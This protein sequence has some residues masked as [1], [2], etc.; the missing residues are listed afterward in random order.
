MPSY[1]LSFP[2]LGNPNGRVMEFITDDNEPPR[3]AAVTEIL[4]R[5]GD[6][7]PRNGTVE[8]YETLTLVFLCDFSLVKPG[9]WRL[10]FRAAQSPRPP[11]NLRHLSP[12]I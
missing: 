3:G 7:F 8:V 2:I 5:Y 10:E 12:P 11:K 1:T 4:N 6:L 9:D